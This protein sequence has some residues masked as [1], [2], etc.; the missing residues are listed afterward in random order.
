L[1]IF[2]GKGHHEIPI[3]GKLKAFYSGRGAGTEWFDIHV[4]KAVGSVSGLIQ[5]L[6]AEETEAAKRTEVEVRADEA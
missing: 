3:H 4:S 1:A 2:P 5:E 6:E